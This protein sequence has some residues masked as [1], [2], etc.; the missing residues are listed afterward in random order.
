MPIDQ[1][2]KIIHLMQLFVKCNNSIPS[3]KRWLLQVKYEKCLIF[4]TTNPISHSHPVH[5]VTFFNVLIDKF[6]VCKHIQIIIF[7][8]NYLEKQKQMKQLVVFI[9]N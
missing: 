3:N 4:E 8:H 1:T 2:K 6:I 7:A 5:H 9:Y